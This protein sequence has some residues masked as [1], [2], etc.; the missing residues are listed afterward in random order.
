MEEVNANIK[1]EQVLVDGAAV[2]RER[3]K[4]VV[5]G[6]M[7]I[8]GRTVR[9]ETDTRELSVG[10]VLTIKSPRALDWKVRGA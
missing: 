5:F 7:E 6:D 9:T 8:D 1:I 2:D 10:D 4:I 3:I